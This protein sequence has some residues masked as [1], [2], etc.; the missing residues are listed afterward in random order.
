LAI[1]Q[2]VLRE[3]PEPIAS[4]GCPAEQLFVV[5]DM[6]VRIAEELAAEPE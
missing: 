2:A 4:N 6:G 5:I 1:R 3:P